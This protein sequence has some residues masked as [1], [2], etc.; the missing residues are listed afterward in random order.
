MPLLYDLCCGAGG[1]SRAALSLGW[2]V[3][4]VDIK[5]QPEYPGPFILADAL[6]PPLKPGADLVWVSP[7]CQGYSR[8]IYTPSRWTTPRLVPQL[9]EVAK[10]LGRHYVIENV[11]T[12][13][14]LRDPAR[15]CGY[16][17]GLPLIRHRLF[18]TSFLLPQPPHLRH[19]KD[20]YQVC[21]HSRG[22]ILQ[23]QKAMGLDIKDRWSLAQ[24]VPWAYTWFVLTWARVALSP[25]GSA[26]P[27]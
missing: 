10:A 20:W 21:G 25:Q 18:E 22:T 19:G 9:R 14:D 12:C 7:P 11:A 24:A 17:F 5:P 16:Q 23:W 6:K 1:V 3:V 4:G 27:N 2:E 8:F 15:L 26:A 13:K